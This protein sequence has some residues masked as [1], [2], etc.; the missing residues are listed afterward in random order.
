MEALSAEADPSDFLEAAVP[1]RLALDDVALERSPSFVFAVLRRRFLR[2]LPAWRARRSR[3]E[4]RSALSAA[5]APPFSGAFAEVLV[6]P[7]G[8]VFSVSVLLGASPFPPAAAVV[9]L[10]A[11]P[12]GR[13]AAASGAGAGRLA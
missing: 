3:V 13:C 11:E 6:D 10:G 4:R 2:W 9:V 8:A 5:S 7:A 12:D 1:D